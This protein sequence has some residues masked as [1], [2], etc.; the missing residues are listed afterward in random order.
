MRFEEII[1]CVPPCEVLL[2]VGCD[3]ALLTLLALNKGICKSAIVSDISDACLSKAR[4]NLK[5]HEN[6]EFYVCDGIP[7]QANADCIL[8]CGMGGHTI[9]H[10]LSG[11][12]GRATLVVSPQSHAELVRQKLAEM[13]YAICIDRCFED[14]GKFYDVIRAEKGSSE[15]DELQIHFGVFYKEKNPCLKRKLERRLNELKKGKDANADK[16]KKIS[17][18]LLWQK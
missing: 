8:I 6:C 16:I 2:E 3:H 7:T 18:V 11:Y 17:E 10:I 4:E 13:G 5:S 15:L 1:S 14:K 12:N 9:E